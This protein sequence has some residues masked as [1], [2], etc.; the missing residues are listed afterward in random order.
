MRLVGTHQFHVRAL[1]LSQLRVVFLDEIGNLRYSAME[2]MLDFFING[3]DHVQEALILELFGDF[4]PW[5][6]VSVDVSALNQS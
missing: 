5:H 6:V 1:L 3:C 2:F 4:N